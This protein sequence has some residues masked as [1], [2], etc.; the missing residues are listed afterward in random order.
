[1]CSDFDA[2]AFYFA[3]SVLAF[4]VLALMRH[5]L[6][7]RFECAQAPIVRMQ[8]FAMVGR[9][10]RHARKLMLSLFRGRYEQ[11][12]VALFSIDQQQLDIERIQPGLDPAHDLTRY[13]THRF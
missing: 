3:L 13:S 5:V 7:V 9:F 12:T 4:N 10:L 2:Y 6:P 11:L 1:M 8:V